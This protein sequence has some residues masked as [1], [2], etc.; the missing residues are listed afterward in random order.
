MSNQHSTILADLSCIHSGENK[1]WSTDCLS[2]N[3][4]VNKY[5][6]CN[7]NGSYNA[8]I[9]DRNENVASY[10]QIRGFDNSEVDNKYK[11]VGLN[12]ATDC[13]KSTYFSANYYTWHGFDKYDEGLHLY[14]T[15]TIDENIAIILHKDDGT[16][17]KVVNIP[18]NWFDSECPKMPESLLEVEPIDGT[19]SFMRRSDLIYD[20]LCKLFDNRSKFNL[21]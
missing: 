10:R 8:F 11:D 2:I 15:I 14:F 17:F 16:I 6:N 4:S 20:V 19:Y 12:I 13:F 9:Y 7:A 1:R 18:K 21:W 3:I 5:T